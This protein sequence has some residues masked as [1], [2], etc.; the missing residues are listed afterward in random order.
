MSII[1][2][3]TLNGKPK[4]SYSQYSS[5]NDPEYQDQYYLQYFMG[6]DLP[7]GEFAWMGS[8]A[9]EYIEDVANGVKPPRTGCLSAEDVSI[10]DAVIDYPEGC[11]YEDKIIIDLPEFCV[12]GYTDRTWYKND[13]EIE[14]R[15]YKTLNLDKKA[16][17]YASQEY[18]QT[19]LY[20]YKKESEGLTV[21]NAEVFGL[22]RKGTTLDGTG[23]YKMRLSG[24]YKIISTPYTK[25]RGEKI[26]A[27]ITKTVKNIS[28]EFQIYQKY[29]AEK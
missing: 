18:G 19:A 21:V 14:I 11:V 26:I 7:S 25:E 28:E 6:V 2:P 4:I 3:K 13:N 8:S 23:N 29:F 5:Y 17:F 1:L 27:D 16:E 24:D 12:E 22:G 10:L 20:C 15:D 9:G